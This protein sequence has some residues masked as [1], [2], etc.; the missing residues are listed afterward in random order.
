MDV[1]A[2]ID[3]IVR[4]TTVLIAQLATTGGERTPLA[5]TANQVFVDLA[6]EL[7][8]QG[9]GSKVIVDMFGMALRTYQT[10]LQRLAESNTD[11]GR[12]LWEALFQYLRD[13]AADKPIT[14]AQLLTRFRHDDPIAVRSVLRDQVDSGLVSRT[15]KGDATRYQL[16]QQPDLGEEPPTL[17]RVDH[18]VWMMVHRLAPATAER[19]SETLS[20]GKKQVEESLARLEA[21]GRIRASAGAEGS[22]SSDACI[23]PLGT[24][25]GWEAA[26]FD[27][28]QAMVSSLCERS[29]A[30]PVQDSR[31]A[32]CGLSPTRHRV[33]RSFPI[34]RCRPRGT[35]RRSRAP[36]AT[37]ARRRRAGSWGWQGTG[38]ESCV[39]GK[40]GSI[41]GPQ[42]VCMA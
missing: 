9:L 26:V 11:R 13:N 17:D 2:L 37:A 23:L 7:R 14:R 15:G 8:E 16:A 12:T 28:Y 34:R 3:A 19:L 24:P 36:P 21:D 40:H 39:L 42:P 35:R 6:R 31:A 41:R 30:C 18:M 32:R 5:H 25:R 4:Q 38:R 10:K 33:W 22:Y 20:L 29:G 27:H 1:A